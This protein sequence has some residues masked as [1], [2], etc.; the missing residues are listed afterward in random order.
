M[1][2]SPPGGL[3][4]AGEGV[5][6]ADVAPIEH[7]VEPAKRQGGRKGPVIVCDR[8]KAKGLQEL[9]AKNSED[10][11]EVSAKEHRSMV[12]GVHEDV[13][14]QETANLDDPFVA[15]QP[16]MHVHEQ[17]PAGV[18][19]EFDAAMGQEGAS[20]FFP[21]YGQVDM[22]HVEQR[23]PAEDGV[24]VRPGLQQNV[25]LVSAVPV[26]QGVAQEV[27]LAM[28]AGARH[29]VVD[30]LKQGDIGL[31]VAE[32]L[33]H[34]VRMVLAIDSADALVDVVGE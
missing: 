7:P 22:V 15:G 30:L 5:M 23:K 26:V 16:E 31:V 20:A 17:E 18:A 29:S 21:A 27:D 33:D 32:D 11:V 1:V 10:V 25:S 2:G 19:V 28:V 24:A 3:R 6:V 34:P 8:L 13:G 14:C 12:M 4:M 9:S